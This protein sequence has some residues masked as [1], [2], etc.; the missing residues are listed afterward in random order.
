MPRTDIAA[1]HLNASPERVYAALVDPVA[2]AS[3]L[4]PEGMR[5]E[6]EHFELSEGGGYRMVLIYEDV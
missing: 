1:R 2:L 3:W 4:P 6:F 5:G